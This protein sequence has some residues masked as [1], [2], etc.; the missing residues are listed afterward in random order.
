MKC[1]I[2]ISH[3][4][5]FFQEIWF[6]VTLSL[7]FVLTTPTHKETKKILA[8]VST[9]ADL[10]RPRLLSCAVSLSLSLPWRTIAS[11]GT[12]SLK[13]RLR[14]S[15]NPPMAA[16]APPRRKPRS[17]VTPSVLLSA[18]LTVSVLALLVLSSNKWR[19]FQSGPSY[20]TATVVNVFPHDPEAFTQVNCF[21]F[22]LFEL[23]FN[24][25]ICVFV[26]ID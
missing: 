17:Y 14:E 13:R 26:C 12:K 5:L 2:T 3:I 24:L 16:A 20:E 7:P 8:H 18:V 21:L 9:I 1:E 6:K 11:M 15:Q 10:P 23:M 22:S 19:A 4:T 25:M